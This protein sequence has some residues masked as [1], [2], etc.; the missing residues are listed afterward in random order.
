MRKVEIKAVRTL[1]DGYFRIDEAELR[2]ELPGG[3]MS[4]L[5]RRLSFERGDSAA[6]VVVNESSTMAVL[7]RQFR[8]PTVAKGPGW[9]LE[10]V[11]GTVEVGESPEQC[12]RREIVEELGYET[13]TLRRLCTFYTSPGGSSERIHL[14]RAV[15]GAATRIGDGG[16]NSAEQEDIE[17]VEI[18][19]IEVPELLA[20]GDI[21]DAKTIIGL[22][23]LVRECMKEEGWLRG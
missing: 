6:A 19:L 9:M 16:G 10:L 21:V 2:Y 15:I 1:F 20:S 22:S 4:D 3:R 5:S 8:F 23:W 14:F 17:L 7:A 12:I 13:L 11:A 18:P